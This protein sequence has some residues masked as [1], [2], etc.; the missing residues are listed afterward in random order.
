[1][2][3]IKNILKFIRQQI[4]D[5]FRGGPQ[6]LWRKFRNLPKWALSHIGLV[7][8]YHVYKLTV[9]LKPDFA[10]GYIL[11][12]ETLIELSRF[13]EAFAVWEKAFQLKPEWAGDHNRI[14]SA[15][16]YCGEFWAAKAIMQKILDQRNKF[17][18]D[19]Q[20]DK[21]GIRFLREFPTVIGHTGLLDFYVKMG[22]LGLRSPTR[23]ILL[24]SPLIANASY[25][26]YWCRYLP[27]MITDPVASDLLA[28]IAKY[29]EDH[30]SAVM[31]NSG[32]Q[33][34]DPFSMEVAVQEQ[35]DAEGR[36]ALLTLTD[37][38]QK[39]GQE[40][41][42]SLGVPPGTWFVALHVRGG[43]VKE[44]NARNADIATYRM[45][46]ESIVARDGWVIRM[47]DPSTAEPMEPM[48]HVIDYANSEARRD[49][50]DV[51]LWARCRFFIGVQSGPLMIPPTF[52][53]PCVATNWSSIGLR[54]Q[55][56]QDLYI[57][58]LHW[59]EKE[60][61]YYSFAEVSSSA[62]ATTES[63]E[64]LSSRGI[65]IIDNTPEEINDVIVEMMDRL[66]GK[67]QY[68]KE[69]E[70]LQERFSQASISSSKNAKTRA[71]REF[72][73]KW[74]NLL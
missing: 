42:E 30:I 4:K 58:K 45:A 2:M 11:L 68:T 33:V 54:Q 32:H 72:L 12:T 52:G 64:Y 39:R 48:P 47:G 16:Y 73:R 9:T 17:A 22:I 74:A 46:M 35:W 55:F 62:L 53:V 25:L 15:F 8:A 27:D 56:T 37:E 67:T 61:R 49:W 34:Y 66:D 20:L 10:R 29:I 26:N 5:V 70:E 44:R 41:L 13:K 7:P 63:G 59:S 6:V 51:F 65:K 60:K 43:R 71:G 21:L 50:M 40:C 36:S 38:D 14:Q 3:R 23:P 57:F 31:D 18:V 1:M 28:P 24:V 69:D 19:H